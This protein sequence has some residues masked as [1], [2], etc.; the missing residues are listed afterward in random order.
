MSIRSDI[1]TLFEQVAKEHDKKLSPLSDDLGLLES[2]L[3]SLCFAIIVARLEDALGIDPFS[4]AE[5][6]GLPVTVGDF[7]K[8]YEN[9]ATGA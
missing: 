6:I 2:G 4:S 8:L 1:T 3:D 9:A 5:D 7:I